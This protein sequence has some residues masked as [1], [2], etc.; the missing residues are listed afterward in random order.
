MTTIILGAVEICTQ[1]NTK[2][3]IE[4]A[5]YEATRVAAR[6]GGTDR[7][8][9]K[10]MKAVLTLRRVEGA[11]FTTSPESI[12]GVPRG[13]PVTVTVTAKFSRNMVIPIRFV[14]EKRLEASC[15]MIKEI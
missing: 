3:A 11:K 4:L 8:V 1:I 12:E 13:T 10:R 6:P 5:A 2:Q 15:T 7:Q 9:W 14:S